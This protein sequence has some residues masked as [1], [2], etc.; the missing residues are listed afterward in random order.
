MGTV[1]WFDAERGVGLVVP[2]DG[3]PD[4]VAYRSAIHG[5]GDGVLLAGER[6]LFNITCD[7]AGVRAD[8]ICPLRAGCGPDTLGSAGF[9]SFGLC[10]GVGEPGLLAARSLGRCGHC[11]SRARWT[12]R[13][14]TLCVRYKARSDMPLR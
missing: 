9:G 4:A 13:H 5:R 11:P 12:V 10:F 7:S 2:E 14:V 8:N 3:G 1:K 6:V